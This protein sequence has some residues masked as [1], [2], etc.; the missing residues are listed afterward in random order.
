M[1]RR[2]CASK[3]RNIAAENDF[4][5]IAPQALRA[6]EQRPKAE[7]ADKMERQ[8]R[9]F[10]KRIRRRTIAVLVVIGVLTVATAIA[11]PYISYRMLTGSFVPIHKIES[12]Q[13]P[14]VVRG[15]ASDGIILADGRTFQIPGF[16]ELPEE[17]A[18]LT[19]AISRGVEI[20]KNGEVTGLMRI[21][22]WCGNDPVREHIVRID[23]SDL[24]MFLN[25]GKTTVPI[26]ESEFTI[27]ENAEKFSDYGWNVSEFYHFRMWRETKDL[28]KN[29]E[30]DQ[31][32]TATPSPR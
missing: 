2:N 24:M 12:L 21:H 6:E 4:Y 23:L 10:L 17:S 15:W 7:T 1:E 13:N 25:L 27:H 5:K 28:A 18:A 11:W 9:K 20:G 16:T 19:A 30:L 32:I 14:V 8:M 26:P 29:E 22:H 3:R 31:G